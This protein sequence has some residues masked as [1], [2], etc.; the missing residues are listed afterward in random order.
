MQAFYYLVIYLIRHY[1]NITEFSYQSVLGYSKVKTV[2]VYV[3]AGLT[4]ILFFQKNFPKL[5]NM[6]EVYSH[7]SHD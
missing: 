2:H 4:I 6:V 7:Q 1:Y 5:N 3:W